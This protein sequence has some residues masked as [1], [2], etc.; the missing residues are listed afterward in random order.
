MIQR[1]NAFG[2]TTASSQA[3]PLT[4]TTAAEE[5]EE[6]TLPYEEA[7]AEAMGA[8]PPLE[9]SSDREWTFEDSRPTGQTETEE[10]DDE[11]ETPQLVQHLTATKAE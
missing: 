2:A 9:S 11:K 4:P 7:L 8:Y 1:A 3:P 6:A 5:E 10:N